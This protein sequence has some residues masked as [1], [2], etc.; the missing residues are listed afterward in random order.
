MTSTENIVFY[1]NGKETIE[2][3]IARLLADFYKLKDWPT[4]RICMAMDEHGSNKNHRRHVIYTPFYNDLFEGMNPSGVLEFGIGSQNPSIPFSMT[5]QLCQ[6]GGSLRA[7]RQI[8]PDAQVFGADIDRACLLDEDKIKSYYIDAL[9]IATIT[10]MWDS[11]KNDF[12]NQEI[13]IIIDDACHR[14]EAN[15]NLLNASIKHLAINGFY[16]IEDITRNNES[17]I[18]GIK[19]WL[20]SHQYDSVLLDIPNDTNQTCNCLAIIHKT[21]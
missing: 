7:W 5:G 9:N 10:E 19:D 12:P 14:L 13:Q 16:I 1:N 2:P 8:F 11:L 20:K 4:T 6:P 18:N 15:L 3:K 21:S 17:Y